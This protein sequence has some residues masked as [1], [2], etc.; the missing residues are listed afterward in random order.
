MYSEYTGE[1]EFYDGLSKA[2]ASIGKTTSYLASF[3]LSTDD[4]MIIVHV[5]AFGKVPAE[6]NAIVGR[7]GFVWLT[8]ITKDARVGVVQSIYVCEYKLYCTFNNN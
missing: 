8:N 6:V 4:Y 5:N 7:K 2:S 3:G 1:F